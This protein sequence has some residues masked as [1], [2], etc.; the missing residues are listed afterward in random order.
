MHKK[1]FK[2]MNIKVFINTYTIVFKM[3]PNSNALFLRVTL[4]YRRI[5][6]HIIKMCLY[7]KK[8]RFYC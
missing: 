4:K 1:V 8:L 6:S 3:L 7:P 5:E 2:Y